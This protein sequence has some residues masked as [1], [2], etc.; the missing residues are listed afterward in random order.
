MSR[1]FFGDYVCD[2]LLFIHT[3]MGCDTTPRL[4]GIAKRASFVKYKDNSFF[5]NQAEMFM[6][7]EATKDEIICAGENALVCLYK[8][9]LLSF[10]M[11]GPII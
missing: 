6:R 3:I 9:T 5:M 10:K 7:I 8:V 2:N 1:K 4:F 11:I